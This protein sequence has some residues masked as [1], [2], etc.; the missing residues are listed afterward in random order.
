MSFQAQ[1]NRVRE[2]VLMAWLHL[3][4]GTG[5]VWRGVRLAVVVV[6]AGCS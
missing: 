5:G 1:C 4:E 6:A 3:M 2:V